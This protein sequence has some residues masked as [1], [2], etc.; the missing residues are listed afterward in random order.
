MITLRKT[1]LSDLEFV[2]NAESHPE[3][4]DFVYQWSYAEHE[5]ALHNSN[6]AHYIILYNEVPSGYIILDDL[7]NPSHSINLRRLV[8]VKKGF[9]IGKI[10]LELIKEIVFCQLDA[11]RLWLDV[12]C[13]NF[14]A[15]QLYQKSGFRQE[16]V[17]QESYLRNGVYVSQFIMAIL[18]DEYL[19]IK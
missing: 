13:D 14:Y 9:G 18:K 7:I 11:H 4:C 2:R 5:A 19:S 17:L 6:L 8:V 10:C 12:F 1:T 15:Y 16:G 3:N